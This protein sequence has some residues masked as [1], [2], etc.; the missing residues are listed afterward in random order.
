MQGLSLVEDTWKAKSMMIKG[1]VSK[2]DTQTPE[3]VLDKVCIVNH[4]HYL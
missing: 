2:C 1:R 3:L 4:S